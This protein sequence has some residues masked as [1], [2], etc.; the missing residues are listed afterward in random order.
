MHVQAGRVLLRCR[1]ITSA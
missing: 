1:R